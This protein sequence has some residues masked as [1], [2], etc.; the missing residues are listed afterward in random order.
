M[1]KGEST[2]R[3]CLAIAADF[4]HWPECYQ[5]LAQK[6]DD[7][8]NENRRYRSAWLIENGKP[9]G[10]GLKYLTF[11]PDCGMFTWTEDVYAAL[12]LSRRADAELV[13]K[14]CEDAWGIVEHG[15]DEAIAPIREREE[16]AEVERLRAENVVCNKWCNDWSAKAASLGRE[17]EKLQA[18]LDEATRLIPPVLENADAFLIG[19]DTEMQATGWW[20]QNR[21]LREWLSRRQAVDKAGLVG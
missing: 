21:L 18:E 3:A 17:V 6:I 13:A 19:T 9:Q 7:E 20:R 5:K 1:T 11:D 2:I 12:H 8:T 15:F 14:D 10:N 16:R 4:Q